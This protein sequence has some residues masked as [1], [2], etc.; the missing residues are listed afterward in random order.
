MKKN[1]FWILVL[2][3]VVFSACAK[4]DDKKETTPSATV[5]IETT[6]EKITEVETTTSETADKE[7]ETGYASGEIQHKY[8]FYNG[9][10]YKYSGVSDDKISEKEFLDKWKNFKHIGYIHK[11]SN[12]EI[13]NEEFEA[14]RMNLGD[15][16]YINPDDLSQIVVYGGKIEVLNIVE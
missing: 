15:K 2:C 8:L 14:S 11:I 9:N 16:V 10:L 3:M 4:D 7:V 13:P 5:P 1:I 6:T 12:T